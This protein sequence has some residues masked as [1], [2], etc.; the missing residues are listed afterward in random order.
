MSVQPVITFINICRF[1]CYK[2]QLVTG[3][4]IYSGITINAQTC[5]P[6]IDFETGTFSQW[7][8]Y[9]GSVSVEND[10]NVISINQTNGAVSNRH[11]MYTANSN[12]GTDPY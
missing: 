8:C 4:I 10:Q 12:A 2:V 9:I 11:T 6:N 7:K 5:P 1:Y 3:L